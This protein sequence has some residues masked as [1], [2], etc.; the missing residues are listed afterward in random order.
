METAQKK[1]RNH[2]ENLGELIGL[3]NETTILHQVRNTWSRFQRDFD[4]TSFLRFAN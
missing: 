3:L 2:R 4:N 1:I